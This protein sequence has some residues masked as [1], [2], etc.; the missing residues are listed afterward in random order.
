V[1]GPVDKG[2]KGADDEKLLDV[3]TVEKL[4]LPPLV[5]DPVVTRN[6]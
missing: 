5:A 4:V 3:N 1:V 6:A 2:A